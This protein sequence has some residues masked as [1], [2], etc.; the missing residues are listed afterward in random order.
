MQATVLM[1]LP[2]LAFIA[3]WFV[4]PSH[5][6]TLLDNAWLLHVAAGAQAVGAAA[7]WKI[8]NFEY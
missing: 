3:I 5:A 7:I 8:V 6:R 4:N 1:A 2:P